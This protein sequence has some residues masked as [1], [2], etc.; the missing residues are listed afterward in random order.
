MCHKLRIIFLIV[1]ISLVGRLSLARPEEVI[2]DYDLKVKLKLKTTESRVYYQEEE[3]TDWNKEIK[4]WRFGFLPPQESLPI[5]LKYENNFYSQEK[6]SPINYYLVYR[7]GEFS[8]IN[9]LNAR[10]KG[11][12][13]F[14]ADSFEKD[15]KINIAVNGE[16]IKTIVVPS[17]GE[18]SQFTIEG[19]ILEPGDNK[20]TFLTLEDTEEKPE[21]EGSKQEAGIKNMRIKIRDNIQWKTLS[22]LSYS[23]ASSEYQYTISNVGLDMFIYF[24]KNIFLISRN[25]DIDLEEYPFIDF[26]LDLEESK[27]EIDIFLGIDYSGDDKID[28]YLRL[29]SFDSLGGIN[30]FK[31]AKDNFKEVDYSIHRFKLKK[32][33]LYLRPKGERKENIYGCILSFKRFNFYNKTSL[34]FKGKELNIDRLRFINTYTKSMVISRKGTADIIAFFDNEK[35]TQSKRNNVQGIRILVPLD[36]KDYQNYPC[37]SFKYNLDDP[38][39]ND[40]DL[41]IL[42]TRGNEILNLKETQY[43]KS[44]NKISINLKKII[45]EKGNI[46]GLIISFIQ[47]DDVD[48][49]LYGTKRWHMFELG[50]LSLYKQFP[51]PIK[52]PLIRNRFLSLVKKRN[53]ALLKIDNNIFYLNDFVN[54]QTSDL[55]GKDT[56]LKRIKLAQGSHNYE[57]FENPVF[58]VEQVILRAANKHRKSCVLRSAQVTFKKI[59]PT[60]YLVRVEGAKDPFWLVFSESYHKE[61]KLYRAGEID[62]QQPYF[63]KIITDYPELGIKETEHL[64]KLT[65][66]DIQYLFREPL[67]ANHYLVN[68]YANAWYIDPKRLGLSENFDLIIYFRPQS[69]FYFGL[70]ISGLTFFICLAYLFLT[71]R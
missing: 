71:R 23:E 63:R 27:A 7:K 55:F 34:V 20:I 26:D 17:N 15:R 4:N 67:N 60:K 58:N 16:D 5:I 35:F 65:P 44:G 59:N 45:S 30:L 46:K 37:F 41:G 24:K 56:L 50:E 28:G 68:G 25:L 13:L 70:M 51:Y 22:K 42:M 2:K 29:D 8:A 21:F 64:M 18:F 66:E 10:I 6:D 19:I 32:V 31:L 1:L 39:I 48:H 38:E 33:I 12:L 61:W 54:W 69:L 40:I 62:T 11:N 43:E 49:S 36:K 3:K 53:P 52:S 47:R 14:W 9:P 57:K